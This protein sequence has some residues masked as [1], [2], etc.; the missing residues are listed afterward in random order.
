ME[1][2]SQLELAARVIQTG[3]GKSITKVLS[4]CTMLWKLGMS[5]DLSSLGLWILGTEVKGIQSGMMMLIVGPSIF[6]DE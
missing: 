2:Y 5:N 6:I 4:K 1:F 3:L